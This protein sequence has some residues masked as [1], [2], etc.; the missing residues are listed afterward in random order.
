IKYFKFLPNQYPDLNLVFM[1][2]F[3]CPQSHSVFTP[4]KNMGYSPVLK[5]QK[6]SL[7]KKCVSGDCLASEFDNIFYNT[8]KIKVQNRGAILFYNNFE[9]IL[10]A[11]KISDHIPIW[12][13]F[14]LL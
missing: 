12:F 2:D 5:G 1:G 9:N 4:L 3:N 10:E 14:T 11:R 6:T 13:Q 8:A 7:K